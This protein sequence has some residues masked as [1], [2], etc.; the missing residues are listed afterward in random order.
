M[1]KLPIVRWRDYPSSL[2]VIAM[3]LMTEREADVAMEVEV[4]V[5]AIPPGGG[6][7]PRHAV[8]FPR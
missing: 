2:N 8:G 3:V 1:I 5:M 4:W 7:E 6:C